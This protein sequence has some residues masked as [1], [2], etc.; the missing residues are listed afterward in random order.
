MQLR[1]NKR[2]CETLRSAK[3]KMQN[4][5][6]QFK[7][8]KY[9]KHFLGSGFSGMEG[10][11]LIELL[12][13]IVIIGVLSAFLMANFI[14]VRQRTRDAQRKSDLNQIKIALET[15]RADLG[16]YPGALAACGSPLTGGSP[17]TTY[18][19]NIPCDPLGGS[20]SYASVGGTTYTII[21][22]LENGNDQQKDSP[23]VAPC[24]GTSGF[25]F[26]VRNP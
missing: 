10:F 9:G 26:T 2:Q 19:T 13:A 1:G 7:I 14:G 3:F 25:S 18:M 16:Y 24:N 6:L 4:S 12:I 23:N 22:C 11:T 8:Q 17:A 21:S 20:Y 15:Y 5:K